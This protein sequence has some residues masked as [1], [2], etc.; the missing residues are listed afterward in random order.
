MRNE[1]GK[2]RKYFYPIF[3]LGRP[4]CIRKVHVT[5]VQML[6]DQPTEQPN[7]NMVQGETVDKTIG[8]IQN[9]NRKSYSRV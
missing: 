4:Q 7:K 8:S 5:V 6:G 2:F 1:S 9:P 3:L